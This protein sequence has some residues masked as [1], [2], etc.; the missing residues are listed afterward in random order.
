[1]KLSACVPYEEGGFL[2]YLAENFI[3]PQNKDLYEYAK[4]INC[5]IYELYLNK[6]LNV[7]NEVQKYFLLF[8]GEMHKTYQSIILLTQ[9][10]LEEDAFTLLRRLYEML[11]KLLAISKDKANIERIKKDESYEYYKFNKK[12]KNNEPGMEIFK[13]R[14]VNFDEAIGE[15]TTVAEWAKLAEMTNV[16]NL[17]YAILCNSSHAGYSSINSSSKK[18]ES[19]IMISLI[20]SYKNYNLIVTS[21]ISIMFELTKLLNNELDLQIDKNIFSN[22]EGK[23]EKY[24]E[25]D[26]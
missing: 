4:E 22:Y 17:E 25:Q 11:F 19:E 13:E 10:G 3:L 15:K 2:N 14:N 20:P 8:W 6:R 1:M 16:Y 7:N 12:I 24:S 18:N 9:R 5:W 21:A 23:L 26:R